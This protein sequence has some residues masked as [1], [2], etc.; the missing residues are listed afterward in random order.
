MRPS[1]SSLTRHPS[2][3]LPRRTLPQAHNSTVRS[4][5]SFLAQTRGGSVSPVPLFKT[6]TLSPI[7][8]PPQAPSPWSRCQTVHPPARPVTLP[9]SRT[10]ASV[11]CS[12]D[13]ALVKGTMTLPSPNPVTSSTCPQPGRPGES[14]PPAFVTLITVVLRSVPVPE[15]ASSLPAPHGGPINADNAADWV[16][17]WEGLSSETCM[18]DE[19]EGSPL[20]GGE[21]KCLLRTEELEFVGRTQLRHP[22][23][24]HCP[25]WQP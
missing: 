7:P 14:H 8:L 25:V 11:P 3:A 19:P 24:L 1:V 6:S 20:S 15:P 18:L 2:L 9:M 17:P 23:F 10:L 4:T 16:F 21:G 22:L 12:M 5:G 13:S